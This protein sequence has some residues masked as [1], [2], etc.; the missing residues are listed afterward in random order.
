M[1]N[2]KLFLFLLIVIISEQGLYLYI[3][4]GAAKIFSGDLFPLS[5]S[6]IV[7]VSLRSFPWGFY[8]SS[9]KQV[10]LFLQ[11]SNKCLVAFGL[12]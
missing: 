3:Q 7:L 4:P 10:K 2:S 11:L 8:Q 1:I 6:R 12:R 5:L 9:F